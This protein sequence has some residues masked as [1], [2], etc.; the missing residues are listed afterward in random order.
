[1][2]PPPRAAVAKGLQGH[3]WLWDAR[4]E[5]LER[6]LFVSTPRAGP[7]SSSL[8]LVAKAV[9]SFCGVSRLR[10]RTSVL[11]WGHWGVQAPSFSEEPQG[12]SNP[13][14][15]TEPGTH[16]HLHSTLVELCSSDRAPGVARVREQCCASWLECGERGKTPLFHVVQNLLFRAPRILPALSRG[17]ISWL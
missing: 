16:W 15:R 8:R 7:V 6:D 17:E 3:Q 13:P 11:D 4:A 2:G 10:L 14:S 5:A 1:M 9:G 12:L